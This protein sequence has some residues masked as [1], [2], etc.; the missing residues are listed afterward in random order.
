[1]AP[2]TVVME[3]GRSAA[4]LL[5]AEFFRRERVKVLQLPDRP[6]IALDAAFL[7]AF[8]LQVI[9]ISLH[10]FVAHRGLPFRC[11]RARCTALGKE[12]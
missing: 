2:C 1:M 4:H 7:V 12:G 10:E 5:L 3:T 6:D 8:Q 11:G 9:Y